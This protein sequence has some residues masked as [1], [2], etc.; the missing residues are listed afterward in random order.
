MGLFDVNSCTYSLKNVE[1]RFLGLVRALV[2]SVAE[3]VFDMRYKFIYNRF[4][5]NR[6]MDSFTVLLCV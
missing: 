1:Y 3:Y 5:P 2:R 4:S 6:M